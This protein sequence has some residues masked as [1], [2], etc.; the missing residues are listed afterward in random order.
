MKTWLQTGEIPSEA[1]S[2]Q[3]RR[4]LPTRLLDVQAF[5]KSND[6]RLVKCQDI[7]TTPTP[8]YLALSHCWGGNV[9]VQL[10][11]ENIDSW[12]TTGIPF[13]TL[14][15]TFRDAVEITK[16]LDVRYIWIDSMCIIQDR[17]SDWTQ[18]ASLMAEVYG[19]AHCT[20]AALSSKNSSEGCHI[21]A[22]IQTSLSSPYMELNAELYQTSRIRIFLKKPQSWIEEFNGQPAQ[23]GG[24]PHS[25]LRTRAW[26]LQEKELS[27]CTIY[28][29]KGQ[30]LWENGLR[31]GT[32]QVPWQE[33]KPETRSETPRLMQENMFRQ[34]VAAQQYPWY[35]L[36]E[37]YT[38][39]TLSFPTDKLVAF[40]GLAKKFS[41]GRKQYCAG[42]WST[43]L[44]GALLWC[45][46]DYTATR[47]A[48]LA[49][50]WSWASL[51]GSVTYDS[52]RLEADNDS[53]Q[54]EYPEDVYSGLK[55]LR[56]QDVRIDLAYETKPYG[57]VHEGRIV[58][59]GAR[60]IEVEC[61]SEVVRFLDGGQ[62]LTQRKAPIGVFYPDVAEEIAAFRETYCIALQ[63]ESVRSFSHHQFRL[64]QDG[65]MVSMVMGIVVARHRKSEGYRRLGL[66][67]W[68]DESLFD[69]VC[70]TTIELV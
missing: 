24:E 20:L 8:P 51:M 64:K 3:A 10:Q 28:F 67:R 11:D 39:R 15:K 59:G 60:C 17:V 52:L 4:F 19:N 61:G 58:L 21:N 12:L 18:E 54:Y 50:S 41:G 68:I 6:V 57:E 7:R 36:V 25:P 26:V 1:S 34:L 46:K 23:A 40:S 53:A 37:D 38:S 70:T 22:N 45:V 14:P 9:P 63:S 32:A 31:R 13:K 48:Y 30:L 47:P 65:E 5:Q 43:D 69:A 33:L 42:I 44:P 49:P 2:K 29:A 35:E 66:A 62:P 16:Q 56:V 55:T 27:N